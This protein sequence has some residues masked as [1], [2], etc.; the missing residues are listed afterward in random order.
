MSSPIVTNIVVLTDTAD[1]VVYASNHNGIDF[2]NKSNVENDVRGKGNYSGSGDETLII[3]NL[4]EKRNS[5]C[6]YHEL[7]AIKGF[8]GRTSKSTKDS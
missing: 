4:Q 8:K 3:L 1:I 6:Y 5:S 2:S 7:L